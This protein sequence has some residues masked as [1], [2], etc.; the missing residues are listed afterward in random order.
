LKQQTDPLLLYIFPQKLMA[1]Y[2]EQQVEAYH[3]LMDK[4]AED[5]IMRMHVIPLQCGHQQDKKDIRRIRSIIGNPTIPVSQYEALS[6]VSKQLPESFLIEVLSAL[7]EIENGPRVGMFLLHE[8]FRRPD[9][10]YH[11]TPGLSKIALPMTLQLCR[12]MLTAPSSTRDEL[13]VTSA[14]ETFFNSQEAGDYSIQILSQIKSTYSAKWSLPHSVELIIA[15]LTETCPTTLLEVFVDAVDPSSDWRYSSMCFPDDIRKFITRVPVDAL[16]AWCE[17]DPDKRYPQLSFCISPFDNRLGNE[18][19]PNWTDIVSTILS[20]SNAIDQC[21][22]VYRDSIFSTSS[23]GSSLIEQFD[24]LAPLLVP[25]QNHSKLAVR[26]WVA[27][28]QDKINDEVD[29]ARRWEARSKF[30]YESP[31]FE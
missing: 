11:P 21:L 6:S 1:A 10:V 4:A 9:E 2:A 5:D 8:H 20:Q 23:A 25:L 16:I 17:L 12:S 26:E 24:A 19:L 3:R 13:Y 28:V 15:T 29:I 18:V 27:D 30:S 7:C 22:E 14:I 31:T